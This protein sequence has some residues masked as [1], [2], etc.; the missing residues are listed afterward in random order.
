MRLGSRRRALVSPSVGVPAVHV[1]LVAP[2]PSRVSLDDH[3]IG[4]RTPDLKVVARWKL[5]AQKGK[6]ASDPWEE[7]NMEEECR[8]EKAV[9]H[10]YNPRNKSWRVDE[11][12]VKMQDKVS[13][14]A[15]VCTCVCV[16]G[17]GGGGE[18][19]INTDKRCKI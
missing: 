12:T 19:V 18:G 2:Q 7:F 1:C 6:E 10:L 13:N 11:I 15:R 5:I 4:P 14:A 16:W 8:E 9:R 3:F 17:G